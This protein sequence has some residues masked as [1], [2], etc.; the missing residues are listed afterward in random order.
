N[1][2]TVDPARVLSK[3]GAELPAANVHLIPIPPNSANTDLLW[4][5][6]A[7]VI[8]VDPDSYDLNHARPNESLSAESARFLQ[9]LGP[10]LR[11]AINHEG[12]SWQVPY[13]WIRNYMAHELLV[14]LKGNKIRLRDDEYEKVEQQAE[15]SIGHLIDAGYGVVGAL[16]DLKPA[17]I[18][19]YSVHPED[20]SEHELR[21]IAGGVI[22]Q[23]FAS[24]NKQKQLEKQLRSRIDSLRYELRNSYTHRPTASTW[25]KRTFRRLTQ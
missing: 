25:V 3:W 21:L 18:D 22:Q 16:T 4:Q 10:D 19:R 5:R 13:R 23:L 1:W 24:L 12:S 9:L 17:P 7:S 2:N 8:G 11:K 6:F 14:P 20:V 15:S